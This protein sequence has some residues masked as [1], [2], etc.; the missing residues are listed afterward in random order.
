[1]LEATLAEPRGRNNVNEGCRPALFG[2]LV[3][4]RRKP[5]IC[6]QERARQAKKRQ[7][8]HD[9]QLMG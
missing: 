3:H 1:M 8:L 9:I 6:R 2:E 5:L 7:Q 4:S